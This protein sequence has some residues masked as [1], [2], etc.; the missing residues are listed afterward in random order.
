MPAKKEIVNWRELSKSK[1][2]AFLLAHPTIADSA[3]TDEKRLDG[4]SRSDFLKRI[5]GRAK[6]S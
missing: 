2:L 3:H 5:Y 4:E 6:K 1:K